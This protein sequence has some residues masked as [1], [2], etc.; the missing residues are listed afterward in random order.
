[1][2]PNIIKQKL[3][4]HQG[5]KV[6]VKL[7]G[8]RGKTDKFIGILKDFYPQIFTI[9]VDGQTRSFS[10]TELINGDVVLSFI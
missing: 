1:M 10:Y 9:D 4:P 8:M 5:E 2:N 3:L 7:F 6:L